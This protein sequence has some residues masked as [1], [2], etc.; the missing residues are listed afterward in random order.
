MTTISPDG[1]Y[2]AA[3]SKRRMLKVWDV[4]TGQ[5]GQFDALDAP[6][7]PTAH[8]VYPLISAGHTFSADGRYLYAYSTP[9]VLRLDPADLHVTAQANSPT[10]I[11]GNIAA[12]P[13]TDDVIGA[14]VAGRIFRWNMATGEIVASGRSTDASLLGFV[15]VSPDG[16]LVAAFHQFSSRMA[17]FDAATLR[18]IGRPI[19]VSD[20]LFRPQFTADG[21][22]LAGN[23]IWNATATH[24]TMDPTSGWRPPAGRPAAT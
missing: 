8:A 10:L 6:G 5:L 17:L 4:E 23:G 22:F 24:W 18:P 15:T 2:V 11:W 7:D 16:S 12:V 20:N 3:I 21:A 9:T 19:P 1:R 14:G 13:G